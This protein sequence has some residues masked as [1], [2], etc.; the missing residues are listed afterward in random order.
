[1]NKA[2]QII[3]VVVLVVAQ[4][5]SGTLNAAAEALSCVP[6]RCC[7][8]TDPKMMEHTGTMKM[9]DNCSPQEAAACCHVESYPPKMDASLTTA[10]GSMF[11]RINMLGNVADDAGELTQI[12]DVLQRHDGDGWLKIPRVPIYLRTLSLLC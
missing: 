4:L 8:A 12:R 7:C 11:D 10:A 2:H 3:I 5:A 1:M 9:P 6:K